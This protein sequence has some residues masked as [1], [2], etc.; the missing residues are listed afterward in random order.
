MQSAAVSRGQ[1]QGGIAGSPV[2]DAS[3]SHNFRARPQ[4]VRGVGNVLYS[5]YEHW[6]ADK[7]PKRYDTRQSLNLKHASALIRSLHIVRYVFHQ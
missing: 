7:E 1:G 2:M 6:S 4:V 3:L 5:H